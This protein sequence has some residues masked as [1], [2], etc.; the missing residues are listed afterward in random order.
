MAESAITY[1]AS[2]NISPMRFV[3]LVAGTDY[4]V[5]Q[6][7]GA[8]DSVIGV[9]GTFTERFDSVYH[10]T[11]GHACKVADPTQIP[12]LELGG[13]VSA[14]DYLRS[15]SSGRGVAGSTTISS[16]QEFGAIAL[17][18]GRTGEFIPV[19]V[20]KFMGVAGVSGT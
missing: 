4:T 18:N 5:V 8:N 11:D 6:C 13:I 16:H 12:L 10:A 14:N 20:V 9:S 2:G 15:D 3:K 7:S 1:N 19:R 17:R